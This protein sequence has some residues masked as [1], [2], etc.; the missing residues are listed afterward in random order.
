MDMGDDEKTNDKGEKNKRK[1]IIFKVFLFLV[2][3]GVS[4]LLTI[5][6]YNPETDVATG[7]ASYHRATYVI[8]GAVAVF[9]CLLFSLIYG[10]KI[11]TR[12][13]FVLLLAFFSTIWIFA[14][15]IPLIDM[16]VPIIEP[17]DKSGQE[18]LEED[19]LFFE[20]VQEEPDQ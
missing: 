13:L 18:M 9:I 11:F 6:L 14:F 7:E 2:F 15:I 3:I 8:S 20:E 17:V 19:T 12:I 5:Y 1:E 4:V 10:F 16:P